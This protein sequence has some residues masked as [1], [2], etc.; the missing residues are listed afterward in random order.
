MERHISRQEAKSESETATIDKETEVGDE[1][2]LRDI[3][4]IPEG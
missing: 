1:L 4:R 2:Y 3:D